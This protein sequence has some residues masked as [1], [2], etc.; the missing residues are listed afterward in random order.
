MFFSGV[1]VKISRLSVKN[2]WFKKRR[3]KMKFIKYLILSACFFISM[4]WA[5][6]SNKGVFVELTSEIDLHIFKNPLGLWRTGGGVGYKYNSSNENY[7]G[8]FQADLNINTN[9][10]EFSG[11]SGAFNFEYGYEFRRDRSFSYGVNISPVVTSVSYKNVSG[12]ETLFLDLVGSLGI[13]GNIKIDDSFLI[14]IQGRLNSLW[15][16][17]Y[18]ISP[19]GKRVPPTTFGASFTVKGKY[20]F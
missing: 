5:G 13:F 7:F 17:S 2:L 9:I 1:V 20:L 19:G 10:P 16:Y 11:V 18:I 6:M 3:R 12:S 14:S 8:Y 15:L 4:A